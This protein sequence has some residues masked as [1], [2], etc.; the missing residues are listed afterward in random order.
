MQM[1]RTEIIEQLKGI[2]LS[3]DQLGSE[4][5]QNCDESSDLMTD[6]GLNSV[7]MLYL[8]IAIEETFNIRFDNVGMTDFTTLGDVVDYIEGKLR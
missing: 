5:I 3:A 7:S 1:S 4:R 2:L 8:V 6:F